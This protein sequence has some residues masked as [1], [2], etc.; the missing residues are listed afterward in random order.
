MALTLPALPVDAGSAPGLALLCSLQ[1]WGQDCHC[2]HFQT[3][4]QA[5]EASARVSL[6]GGGGGA[7]THAGALRAAFL[8]RMARVWPEVSGRWCRRELLWSWAALQ[9]CRD[10]TAGNKTFHFL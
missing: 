3:G 6:W 10:V 1:P 8:G 4:R 9:K 2:F 7:W 5:L